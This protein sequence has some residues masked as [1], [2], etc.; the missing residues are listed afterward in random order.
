MAA[1]V[2]AGH[3]GSVREL[4]GVARSDL[5]EQD[6]FV[7][8]Q[9][10]RV[11]RLAQLVLVPRGRPVSGRLAMI[12]SG[13]PPLSRMN[14]SRRL[15]GFDPLHP[16][17]GGAQ[18]PRDQRRHDDRDDEEGRDLDAFGALEDVHDR[19]VDEDHCQQQVADPALALPARRERDGQGRRSHQ[20]EHA[21]RVSAALRV[22]VGPEKDRDDEGDAVKISTSGRLA[23]AHSGAMPYRGR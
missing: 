8:R 10:M 3:L 16:Q 1:D 11:A 22:D 20:H 15:V 23:L 21:G 4:G 12:R 13:A 9:V 14:R 7:D 17:L 2:G 19:G 6:A 5:D 18:H